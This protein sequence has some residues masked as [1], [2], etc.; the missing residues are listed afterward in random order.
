MKSKPAQTPIDHL[1][2][3]IYHNIKIMITRH[4]LKPMPETTELRTFIL[5]YINHQPGAETILMR[6]LMSFYRLDEFT[7]KEILDIINSRVKALED[8]GYL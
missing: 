8:Q 7:S 1:V 6:E 5:D 4:N 3:S 2:A